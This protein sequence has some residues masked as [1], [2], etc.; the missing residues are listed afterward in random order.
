MKILKNLNDI[1]LKYFNKFYQTWHI[2]LRRMRIFQLHYYA[3]WVLG[4]PKLCT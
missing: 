4:S 2:N 3:L 1:L